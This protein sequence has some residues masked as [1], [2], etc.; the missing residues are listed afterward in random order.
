MDYQKLF[1]PGIS[2]ETIRA[3]RAGG[4]KALGVV[5][6]HVPP[7]LLHAAGVLPVTGGRRHSGRTCAV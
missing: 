2:D 7:E 4:K 5:C 6:C 3:W 1:E